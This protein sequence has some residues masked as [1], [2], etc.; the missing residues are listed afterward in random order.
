MTYKQVNIYILLRKKTWKL[1]ITSQ[2]SLTL[3][4]NAGRNTKKE[5]LL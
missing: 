1:F 5:I 2:V 3:L 4:L